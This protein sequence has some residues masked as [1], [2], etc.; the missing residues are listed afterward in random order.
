MAPTHCEVASM[1]AR[2]VT[3]R[4]AGAGEYYVRKLPSYYLDA[5]EPA[6]IWHGQGAEMLGLVP[7]ADVG[8][9]PDPSRR[10]SFGP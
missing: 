1:T 2:V 7:T 3:L 4:G 9:R 8:P 6:G 5:G 10:H